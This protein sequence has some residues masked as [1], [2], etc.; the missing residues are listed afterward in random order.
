MHE[1]EG[2]P[3]SENPR[4]VRAEV[5]LRKEYPLPNALTVLNPSY[6]VKKSTGFSQLR[7]PFC[8]MYRILFVRK[9]RSALSYTKTL[10][11]KQSSHVLTQLLDPSCLNRYIETFIVSVHASTF[12]RF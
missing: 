2:I 9:I 7:I 1:E 3:F 8:R 5:F 11:L 6:L 12:S 10:L 4:P